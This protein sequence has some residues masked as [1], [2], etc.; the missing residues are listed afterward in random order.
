MQC[1]L[2]LCSPC[3]LVQLII[4]SFRF[5]LEAWWIISALSNQLSRNI[6]EHRIF[7]NNLFQFAMKHKISHFT[8]FSF[9]FVLLSHSLNSSLFLYLSI[10]FGFQLRVLHLRL[11]Y[12]NNTESSKKGARMTASSPADETSKKSRNKKHRTERIFFIENTRTTISEYWNEE[13]VERKIGG[14]KQQQMYEEL[15][16]RLVLVRVFFSKTQRRSLNFHEWGTFG[17]FRCIFNGFSFYKNGVVWR[18]VETFSCLFNDAA[19][20]NTIQ[21]VVFR[22]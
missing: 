9:V 18:E 19:E 7:V 22:D 13:M 5:S 1:L 8:N 11:Y 12:N 20:I 15:K 3:L 17:S 4:K 21:R 14:R 6:R 2:G 10:C 16:H